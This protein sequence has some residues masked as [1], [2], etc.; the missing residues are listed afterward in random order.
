MVAD[1]W[2][3]RQC[4]DRFERAIATWPSPVE[5]L[6]GKYLRAI[7]SPKIRDDQVLVNIARRGTS[8]QGVTCR[9]SRKRYGKDLNS[10]VFTPKGLHSKA[11]GCGVPQPWETRR[12]LHC[13]PEGVAQ[14]IAL[15]RRRGLATP[16]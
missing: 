5:P 3:R 12:N 14:E 4:G 13:Y 7:R 15:G 11:R 9:S 16:S 1:A 8:E 10:K 2:S 6:R